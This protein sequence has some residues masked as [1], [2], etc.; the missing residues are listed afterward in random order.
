MWNMQSRIAEFDSQRFESLGPGYLAVSLLGEA[1]EVADA[2]KKLWRT[3]P[4]IGSANGFSSI[5]ADARRAIADE[6]AD[7]VILSVV[8]ANHL[9]IDVEEAV[10]RKLQIIAERLEVGYYGHEARQA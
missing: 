8:L 4:R 10:D 1:G 3:D 6:L 7:V 2:I 5:P 9:E